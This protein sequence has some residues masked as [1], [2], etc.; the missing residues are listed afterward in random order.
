MAQ[1]PNQE[2][3]KKILA[4]EA[5]ADDAAIVEL[6]CPEITDQRAD[7]LEIFPRTKSLVSLVCKMNRKNIHNYRDRLGGFQDWVERVVSSRDVANYRRKVSDPET[8]SIWQSLSYGI[9]NKSS[10]CLAVCPAG[11]EVIGPFLDDRQTYLDEVV[12]PFQNKEESIY[13][14]PA[15]DAEQYVAKRF[16]HKKIRL[17]GNGLRAGSAR[18]FLES[19][20]LIF[21]R[22]QSERKIR[23]KESPRL[24]KQFARCFPS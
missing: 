20:P 18:S 11:E 22:G 8:T 7:I 15:S 17:I 5:G 4:L 6:E 9:C 12:K 19:L 16:P 1:A 10:Y 2:L 23:S 24:M 14:V 21:Q 13:V 3:K